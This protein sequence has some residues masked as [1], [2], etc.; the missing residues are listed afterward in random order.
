MKNFELLVTFLVIG[1][2]MTG[3][4]TAFGEWIRCGIKKRNYKRMY[5]GR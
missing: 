2:V 3:L 1:V 5:G 4:G